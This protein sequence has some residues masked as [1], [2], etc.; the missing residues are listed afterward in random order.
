MA[1]RSP[2]IAAES[3]WMV[4]GGVEPCDVADQRPPMD[5]PRHTLTTRLDLLSR[6]ALS[7]GQ[8]IALVRRLEMYLLGRPEE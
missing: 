1:K 6:A 7:V 5:K 8:R 3:F 2:I 4:I